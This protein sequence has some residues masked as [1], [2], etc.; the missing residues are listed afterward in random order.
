MSGL[1]P[2]RPAPTLSSRLAPGARRGSDPIAARFAGLAASSGVEV[3]LAPLFGKPQLFRAH[4]RIPTNRPFQGPPRAILA[5]WVGCT[6]TLADG[7]RQI[8]HVL[9]PGDLLLPFEDGNGSYLSAITPVTVVQSLRGEADVWTSP[10]IHRSLAATN[11]QL[12]NQ[13]VRL[14]RQHAY[15]RL[16]HLLLELR[17]RMRLAGEGAE[18]SFPMPL[19]QELLAD[20]LGLTSVHV[21]RTLQQMRRDAMVVLSG[22]IVELPDPAA[23]ARIADYRPRPAP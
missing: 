23:L 8:Q 22:R 1:G 7:R 10:A 4:A 15:E 17:D 9:V 20:V 14:G 11:E 19:T 13:I 2:F 6:R 12:L 16:A 21:N 18:R 3:D 5:G